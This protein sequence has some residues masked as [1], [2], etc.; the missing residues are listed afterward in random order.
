MIHSNLSHSFSVFTK[1]QKDQTNIEHCSHPSTDAD[2]RFIWL[3]WAQKCT[4]ELHLQTELYCHTWDILINISCDEE[5]LS[6]VAC[7]REYSSG[8]V[9]NSTTAH[10]PCRSLEVGI[11]QVCRTAVLEFFLVNYWNCDL[12]AFRSSCRAHISRAACRHHLSGL[13][14]PAQ[15]RNTASLAYSLATLVRR[16]Y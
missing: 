8:M 7:W 2:V 14:R 16:P 13:A 15:A 4:K 10:K 6:L 12:L 3:T 1:E 11:G 9:N 5:T